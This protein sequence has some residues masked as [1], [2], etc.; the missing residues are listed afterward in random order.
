[1]YQPTLSVVP[2]KSWKRNLICFTLLQVISQEEH[3]K[4]T[5]KVEIMHIYRLHNR[6]TSSRN[7]TSHVRTENVPT[8]KRIIRWQAIVISVSTNLIIFPYY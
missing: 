5:C 1:M 2:K 6:P 7:M 4:A 8:C 3:L